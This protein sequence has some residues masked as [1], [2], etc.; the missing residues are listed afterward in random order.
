MRLSRLLCCLLATLALG[1]AWM[2]LAQA[3]T[4]GVNGLFT[5]DQP[6]LS[7]S[8]DSLGSGSN[9][10]SSGPGLKLVKTF[11][12][13]RK[14]VD[15]SGRLVVLRLQ[16]SFTQMGRQYGGLMWAE[17][18][19]MYYEVIHQYDENSVI[20]PDISLKDFNLSQSPSSCASGSRRMDTS[21]GQRSTWGHCSDNHRKAR[22][23][24]PIQERFHK[25]ANPLICME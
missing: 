4:A 3:E 9:G 17:I 18:G 6:S 5:N 1:C 11:Q 15:K 19:K 7:G 21:H 8:R 16:G 13:G 20:C 2:V 25:R 23:G 24:L 10:H 12:N 14:Y 22:A